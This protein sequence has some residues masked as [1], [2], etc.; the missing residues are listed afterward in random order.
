MNEYLV[1][2]NDATV[3][4]EGTVQWI[5][6]A[7]SEKDALSQIDNM[8]IVP[9]NQAVEELCKKRGC[10]CIPNFYPRHRENLTVAS[11]K[12]IHAKYGKAVQLYYEVGR[13]EDIES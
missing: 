7:T 1:Q 5:V 9:H 6:S 10:K 4:G 8:W 2:Y 12:D 3:G 11:L 13:M